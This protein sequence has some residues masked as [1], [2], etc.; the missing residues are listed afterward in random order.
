MSTPSEYCLTDARFG[1]KYAD[2]FKGLSWDDL[3]EIDLNEYIWRKYKKLSLFYKLVI[4][5]KIKKHNNN[6]GCL[7]KSELVKAYKDLEPC[8][9]INSTETP[10]SSDHFNLIH[11]TTGPNTGLISDKEY[12]QEVISYY[13]ITSYPNIKYLILSIGVYDTNWLKKMMEYVD[14]LYYI[15]SSIDLDFLKSLTDDEAKKFIWCRKSHI[16]YLGRRLDEIQYHQLEI[17][18]KAHK[19]FYSVYSLDLLTGPYGD[20]PGYSHIYLDN[21]DT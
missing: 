10:D 13:V 16:K 21:V 8:L 3:Y 12:F 15:N 17:M 6:I 14:Y 2:I 1:K 18:C 7:Y 5:Q 4:T 20:V 9:V 19:D 11:V